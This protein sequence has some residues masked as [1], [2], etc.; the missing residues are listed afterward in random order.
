GVRLLLLNGYYF[1]VHYKRIISDE[2]IKSRWYCHN[3]RHIRCKSIVHTLNDEIISVKESI[4]NPSFSGP[5]FCTSSHGKV[6]VTY[7]GYNFSKQYSTEKKTRWLCSSGKC[8]K[9]NK[10]SRELKARWVCSTHYSKGCR[11]AHICTYGEEIIKQNHD[12]THP[13]PHNGP[14]TFCKS[15]RGTTLL[16]YGLYTFCKMYTKEMKTR[17]VCSTHFCKG[18]RAHLW[19]YGNDIIRKNCDH[20]HLPSPRVR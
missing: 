13:P 17:W 16:K 10:Y 12:H 18:C 19:T 7:R 2:V 3:G 1:S 11:R 20:N 6:M 8:C 15:Q 9:A 14:L 4:I 5:Q